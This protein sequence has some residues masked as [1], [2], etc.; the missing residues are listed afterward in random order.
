MIQEGSHKLKFLNKKDF[1]FLQKQVK[2]N[3]YS[4]ASGMNSIKKIVTRYWCK[5]HTKK[6]K[7]HSRNH[8]NKKI[9]KN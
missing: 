5:M 4:K 2:Y 6:S 8:C 3:R 9:F 1:K 7:N